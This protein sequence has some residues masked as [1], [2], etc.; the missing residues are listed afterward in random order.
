MF[1]FRSSIMAAALF[2][3]VSVPVNA[4]NGPSVAVSILPL[5]SLVASVMAGVGEPTLIIPRQASPHRYSLRPSQV[6]AISEADI[7]FWTEPTFLPYLSKAAQNSKAKLVSLGTQ[8]GVIRLKAREGGVWEGHDHGESH[9][10]HG[11]HNDKHGDKHVE[12]AN[13]MDQHTWL[14]PL[15]ARAMTEGIV[16]ALVSVD[17][18]NASR[19]KTNGADLRKSLTALVKRID[20][21]VSVVRGK[22]FIVFHDAYQYFE[23]RFKIPAS[24]SVLAHSGQAPSAKRLYQIRKKILNKNSV[25]V[26]REP[27]FDAKLAESLVNGTGARIGTVDPIG[28]SLKPGPG[29]YALLIQNLASSLVDCLKS[30]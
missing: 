22:S 8:S 14:D 6:R 26:F 27:Q 21:E 12:I 25:C 24:G 18:A 1:R 19:Y 28:I 3:G 7:V 30:R 5:H 17:P 10:D 29:A 9:G 4:A 11:K 2:C 15:N 13:H 23:K 16:R 20:G